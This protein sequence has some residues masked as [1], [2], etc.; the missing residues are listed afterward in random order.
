MT[1]NGTRGILV[2]AVLVFLGNLP[3]PAAAQIG[4]G[5]G[6]SSGAYALEEG[7]R[8]LK[9]AAVP[10]PGYSEVLGFSLGVIGMA[11]YKM[12]RHDDDLPPSST[13]IFGFYSEN[14]SW[15]GMAFQTFH[16][17]RDNWRA[18]AAFGTGSIKY[19][20]NP[21]SAGP[22]FPDLF[23]DYTTVSDFLFLKGSRR[24][25]EKLYLGAEA[26]VWS[27]KV[28]IDPG[29]IELP[30]EFYSSLG[31]NAEWDGRD[32]IMYPTSGTDINVRFDVYDD[33]LGSDR[34]FRKLK[35]TVSG[36]TTLG[37]S[38]RV[39]AGRLFSDSAFGDVPFSGQAIVSGK[40][41]LRGYA[42]GRYRG[43]KLLTLETEY[44]WNFW[45]R[46]GAVGFAG[47]GFVGG[48]WSDFSIGDT[49]P[50]AGIGLRFRMIESFRINARIDY[51]WGKNDQALYIGLGEAY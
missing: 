25:W 17:D 10:I 45:K 40:K 20:F 44:R 34:D 35:I 39:L 2:A 9:F 31:M 11:Y 36:Y 4:G 43:D 8:N 13:G 47:V 37:D 29:L 49:L 30:D 38:T 50:G 32:H 23:L 3:G 21:S 42:N 41:N 18:T 6:G 48:D 46:W 16:L 22:G 24:T 12:D 28:G 7:E 14:N 5:S 26:L 27:A 51:G 1:G 15:I 33:A 19:Q